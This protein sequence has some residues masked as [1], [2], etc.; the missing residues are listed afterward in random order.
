MKTL[1]EVG[2]EILSNNPSTF[3]IFAGCEY[4][5]KQKYIEHLTAYYGKCV[6]SSN[7]SDVMS[8]M[9]TRHIIPLQP[10]LYVVRY[11]DQFVSSLNDASAS[12][13]PISKI[14]GTLVCLYENDKQ[15]SKLSKYLGEYTVVIDNI[16]LN[17]ISKYLKSDFPNLNSRFIDIAANISSNYSQ[18]KNI[19]QGMSLCDSSL[20]S[21][22]NDEQLSKLFGYCADYGEDSFKLGVASR[23]FS[24]LISFVTDDADFDSL[25]Y[26]MLSVCIDLDRIMDSPN[27]QCSIKPYAKYW[28]REDVYYFFM[29]CYKKLIQSRSSYS[30]SKENLIYLLG[31]L[32]FERIPALE[33]ME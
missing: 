33:V 16:S 28:T 21:S 3:Y 25:M 5:I 12:K 11:D 27:Y 7:V 20:L 32:Q 23:N 13:L 22:M 29:H 4:G 14:V 17:L 10:C 8:M 30:S 31:I 1:Q 2:I 26:S 18:A 6:E 9:N 19:C 24:Y 15:L